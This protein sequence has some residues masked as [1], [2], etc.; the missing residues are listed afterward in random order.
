MFQHIALKMKF[1]AYK[2]GYTWLRYISIL[3]QIVKSSFSI[4]PYAIHIS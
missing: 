2:L 1:R 4:E 3:A